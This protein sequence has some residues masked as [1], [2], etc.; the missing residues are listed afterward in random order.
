MKTDLTAFRGNCEAHC[1]K[2]LAARLVAFVAEGTHSE[3]KV[4][5]AQTRLYQNLTGNA[6]CMAFYDV[7]N[8]KLCTLFQGEGLT[9]REP[10]LDETDFERF[11]ETVEP[12]LQAKRDVLWVL[13]GRAD[14]NGPKVKKK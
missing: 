14:S 2:E 3:I 12:L 9:H 8:A 11:V 6:T 4:S 1:R 10:V 7:K 13:C 5:V